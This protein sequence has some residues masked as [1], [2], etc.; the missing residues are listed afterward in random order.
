MGGLLER[1]QQRT[2]GEWTTKN[3]SDCPKNWQQQQPA[4][5]GIFLPSGDAHPI[6]SAHIAVTSI[7]YYSMPSRRVSPPWTD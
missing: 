5:N 7:P 4:L 2:V 1:A 3:A 6:R